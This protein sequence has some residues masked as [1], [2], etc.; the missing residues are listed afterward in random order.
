MVK[1]LFLVD[2][3]NMNEGKEKLACSVFDGKIVISGGYS[4]EYWDGY[5]SVEAYNHHEDK[6]IFLPDMQFGR[7]GHSAVSMGNKMFIIGGFGQVYIT[8]PCE[9]YDK[10]SK[11]FSCIEPP[12]ISTF[13]YPY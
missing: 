11:K 3:L 9:V 2:L 7:H 12:G 10:V 4:D 1:L 13:C 5:E 6:W 8:L